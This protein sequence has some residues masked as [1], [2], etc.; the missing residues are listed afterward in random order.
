M[1]KTAARISEEHKLL[2][3]CVEHNPM[4]FAIY[5][6]RDRLIAWNQPYE[7]IHASA[8]AK[9][10]GKAKAGQIRYEDLIRDVADRTLPEAE[11]EAYVRERVRKQRH[12]DG[13][14]IDRFYP[15]V[16]W[17]RVS[18]FVTP[19]GAVAGFAIDIN[20]LKER[21]EALQKQV[22]RSKQLETRLRLI[23]N[24]D[25]MTELPNR[26]AFLERSE[27][28]YQR[29]KRY[30]GIFSA[31]MMD[32]DDFKSVND[33]YGHD[34]GDEVIIAVAASAAGAL[35]TNVD[36]VGR[37]GGEEFGILLPQTNLENAQNCA[38]RIR[39]SVAA[40]TF[41]SR[42]KQFSVTVS[43]GVSEVDGADDSF[44]HTLSRADGALYDAKRSGRNRVAST[45]RSVLIPNRQANCVDA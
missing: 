39:K 18:K 16:G 36:I 4:P 32:I 27:S 20:E 5:D 14:A 22:E 43:A 15:V 41:T 38:E 33:S 11:R 44:S 17:K 30:S 1:P 6:K 37:L 12:Y 24:T 42:G 10:S 13:G 34:T 40:L 35:R 3:E 28:E 45:C 8:F 29:W 2:V 9:L 31:V 7:S 25:A 21:E 23:A 19:S 26:R